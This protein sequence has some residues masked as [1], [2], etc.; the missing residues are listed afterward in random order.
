M[1]VE[2]D[3]MA[4]EEDVAAEV[5]QDV[6]AE[7]DTGEDEPA[8]PRITLVTRVG[9]FQIFEYVFKNQNSKV[10]KTKNKTRKKIRSPSRSSD[11]PPGGQKFM[12]RSAEKGYGHFPNFRE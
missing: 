5:G 10:N 1:E 11:A 2:R 4:V 7:V 8:R 3:D 12:T 9:I 6:A